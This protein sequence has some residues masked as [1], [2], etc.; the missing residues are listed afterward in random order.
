MHPSKIGCIDDSPWALNHHGRTAQNKPTQ[1]LIQA[2]LGVFF[3]FK[4]VFQG[5]EWKYIGQGIGFACSWLGS[6]IG[7][8][9]HPPENHQEWSIPLSNSVAQE[10]K[11][12]NEPM[13]KQSRKLILTVSSQGGWNSASATEVCVF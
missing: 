11:L 6:I 2:L 12:I 4:V 1:P 10:Q 8:P 13:T 5:T 3:I 9:E 7:I